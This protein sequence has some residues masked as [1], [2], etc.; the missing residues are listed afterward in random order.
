MPSHW[1]FRALR[2]FCVRLLVATLLVTGV[3]AVPLIT[4]AEQTGATLVGRVVFRGIVPP[5]EVVAVTRD[6][7]LCG[8]T[9][10]IQPLTV[11]AGTQGVLHAVVSLNSPA[12]PPQTDLPATTSITNDH[13]VF[14]PRV[15]ALR[16]GSLLE[17]SNRDPILHNTHIT[18]QSRTFFNVAMVAGG[19]PV[20]KGIKLP[21]LFHVR[22]DVHRFMQGYVLAFDHPYYSVTQASG[23]F[24]IVGVPSG[25][26]QIKVWHETLGT[27]QREI[28]VPTE[29]NVSLALE[30]P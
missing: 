18:T 10:A 7:E 20:G 11:Q 13:C 9:R 28:T 2:R 29:G 23:E 27:L 22:C 6:Q 17:V 4:P 19:K 15:E 25:Q 16:V 1:Q 3:S 26:H 5:P 14:S 24:R 8:T 12:R 21:G 30:F